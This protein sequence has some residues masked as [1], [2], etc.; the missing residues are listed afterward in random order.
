MNNNDLLIDNYVKQVAIFYP[1]LGQKLALIRVQGWDNQTEAA[2][3]LKL[4]DDPNEH[5]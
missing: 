5:M 4:I 2:E 3:M 1:Q